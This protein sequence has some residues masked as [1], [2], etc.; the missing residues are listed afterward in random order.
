MQLL[1]SS[2]LRSIARL[3]WI[4]RL[5]ANLA[6]A[7]VLPAFAESELPAQRSAASATTLLEQA[8]AL[9]RSGKLAEAEAAYAVALKA[10][11]QLQDQR[12]TSA[13]VKV[14][15]WQAN[16]YRQQGRFTEA[17]QAAE[18]A[19]P[20]HE[21]DFG[22][23]NPYTAYL[24]GLLGAVATRL[25]QYAKAEHHLRAV[26]AAYSRN[27]GGEARNESAANAAHELGNVLVA[28]KR[29]AEAVAV[30]QVG[31]ALRAAIAPRNAAALARATQMLAV[32]FEGT[33]Q[34]A[35]ADATY[36]AA[37]A[38]VEDQGSAVS[39]LVDML[40]GQAVFIAISAGT[41]MPGAPAG[42]PSPRTRMGRRTSPSRPG[43]TVCLP[44][45]PCFATTRPRRR[46]S[47]V[48][49]LRPTTAR[50]RR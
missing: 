6:A 36:K 3:S 47:I 37:V 19:L 25:G 29:S 40:V 18:R 4:C 45:S 15:G 32:A 50:R 10:A 49:L 31:I 13:V 42:A 11:E 44:G 43:S 22:P 38:I 1:L 35:E 48:S 12:D 34:I 41:R 28:Q 23:D 7:A 9:H 2:T 21:A 24:H 39:T 8:T 46:W 27:G 20:L 16:L 26:L 17:L 14:L 33:A 5:P 30:L